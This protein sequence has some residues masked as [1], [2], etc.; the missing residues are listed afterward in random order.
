MQNSDKMNIPD[1]LGVLFS[2][3]FISGINIALSGHLLGYILNLDE[4]GAN[5]FTLKIP[6]MLTI[7]IKGN[8]VIAGFA[9]FSI[10]L[11]IVGFWFSDTAALVFMDRL[12][13]TESNWTACQA[14]ATSISL[15]FC[16]VIGGI[17]FFIQLIRV[18]LKT[19]KDDLN[20]RA[21]N[22]TK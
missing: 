5:M 14:L 16:L 18:V 9:A 22:L 19:P 12:K 11:M 2:T 13:A 20:Q 1:R 8:K 21:K 10:S 7:K 17:K 3:V 15:T 6:F 4:R